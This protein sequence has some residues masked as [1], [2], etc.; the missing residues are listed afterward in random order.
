[1]QDVELLRVFKQDS[2]W[3]GRWIG[4]GGWKSPPRCVRGGRLETSFTLSGTRS[5]DKNPHL[6]PL[7]LTPRLLTH[8]SFYGATPTE[9]RGQGVTLI[10]VTSVG[11][12]GG[13]SCEAAG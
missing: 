9:K 13:R 7:F 11:T 4:L 2:G 8:D 10:V 5:Y 6:P 1:M 12:R 3:I